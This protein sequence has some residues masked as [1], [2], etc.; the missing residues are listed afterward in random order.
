MSGVAGLLLQ[1]IGSYT[2]LQRIM[3]SRLDIDT[4]EAQR[5][6][7]VQV[8]FFILTHFRYTNITHS[9]KDGFNGREHLSLGISLI[10]KHLGTQVSHD[11]RWLKGW[12]R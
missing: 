2:L 9:D 12:G 4:V 1:K 10:F 7:C 8:F 11:K 3:H 6:H 5:E